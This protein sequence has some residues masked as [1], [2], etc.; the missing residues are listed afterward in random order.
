VTPPGSPVP[1]RDGSAPST[2]PNAGVPTQPPRDPT[3]NIL[4][5]ETV[6]GFVTRGG[7]GPCFGLQTEDGV[8][9]ALYSIRQLTL[10]RGQYVRVETEPS[11][12]RIDCGS[13][14]FR[15]IT[16]VEPVS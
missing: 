14:R 15:A 8:D 16:T 1:P 6:V 10:T 12:V 9:Y 7:S 5:T 2:W 3:D 4:D 13:G 11:D